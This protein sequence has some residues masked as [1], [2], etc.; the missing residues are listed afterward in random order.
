MEDRSASDQARQP[1]FVFRLIIFSY[2]KP[3]LVGFS[4]QILF[5]FRYKKEKKKRKQFGVKDMARSGVWE[6]EKQAA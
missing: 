2:R 5:Y 1:L 6:S 3:K 4:G